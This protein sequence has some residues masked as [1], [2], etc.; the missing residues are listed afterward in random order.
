[1]LGFLLEPEGF[2]R[3]VGQFQLALARPSRQQ[4][5]DLV[6][7]KPV[8]PRHVTRAAPMGGLHFVTSLAA[9]L[10]QC[11]GPAVGAALILSQHNPG[12]TRPSRTPRVV[13]GVGS[14][15]TPAPGSPPAARTRPARRR[16]AAR[17][18]APRTGAHPGCTPAHG[19]M[20]PPSISSASSTSFATRAAGVSLPHG[21]SAR[22]PIHPDAA[23]LSAAAGIH[24]HAAQCGMLVPMHACMNEGRPCPTVQQAQ[25]AAATAGAVHRAPRKSRDRRV[26][27]LQLRVPEQVARDG[28]AGAPV[29]DLQPYPR[30][31]LGPQHVPRQVL[32]GERGGAA[33]VRRLPAQLALHVQASQ[34]PVGP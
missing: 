18:P 24:P 10:C 23:R 13:S 9:H 14:Q 6:H 16:S 5:P 32:A 27:R 34:A 8:Q 17:S 33:P 7:S 20:P 3:L 4:L 31:A 30:A 15:G 25:H 19:G 2:W 21:A 1:M 11:W 29:Y 28:L 12:W 22:Q 26:T